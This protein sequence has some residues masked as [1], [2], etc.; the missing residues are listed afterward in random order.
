MRH[1]SG[2]PAFGT[3]I[4]FLLTITIAASAAAIGPGTTD[5][6]DRL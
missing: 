3:P 5:M 2:A 4:P 6:I 1:S